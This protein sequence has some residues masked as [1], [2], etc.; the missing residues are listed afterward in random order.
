MNEPWRRYAK[1]YKPDTKTNTSW[2]L[3]CEV[4]REVKVREIEILLKSQLFFKKLNEKFKLLYNVSNI[5]VSFLM[6]YF[7]SSTAI[8]M[9]TF[10]NIDNYILVKLK[11]CSPAFQLYLF[12]ASF[13]S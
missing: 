12:C 8:Y 11:C 13:I 4:S 2:F 3:L 1:R 9:H 10:L 6:Q 5:K 7:N